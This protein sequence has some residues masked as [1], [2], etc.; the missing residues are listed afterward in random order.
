M[1]GV[2]YIGA[3]GLDA[4]QR[5]L[6]ITA[7][8]IANVNTPAFKRSE[9]RFSELVAPTGAAADGG[10]GLAG[11]GLGRARAVQSQ[12]ELKATLDPAH[13]AIRGEGFIELMGP[14]GRTHL[15]RGGALGVNADGLLATANGMPLKAMISV[16]I[17]VGALSINGAGEVR[18]TGPDGELLGRID[19]A[20]VRDAAD[21]STAGEGLYDVADEAALLTARPGEDGAGMLAQGVLESSNVELSSEMIALLLTQR[22]Y[23]ANAQV[24]QAGDQLMAMANGL[25]R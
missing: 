20:R 19:L 25:R 24:V 6:E 14:G 17:E 12:G 21:L 22:A 16:P 23:A 3:T 5:A 18:A 11:V 8:N 2:F 4:Q 7:N 13:L 1:N 9:V 10:A 15:W